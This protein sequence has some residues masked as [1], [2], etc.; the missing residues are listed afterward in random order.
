MVISVIEQWYFLEYILDLFFYD[1]TLFFNFIGFHFFANVWCFDDDKV[2]YFVPSIVG[3]ASIFDGYSNYM[4]V[5]I[6][7]YV[8]F[9]NKFLVNFLDVALAT[10]EY[11]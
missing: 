10:D 9:L 4:V 7:F 3:V 5:M 8:L 1:K 6:D 2:S 11:S